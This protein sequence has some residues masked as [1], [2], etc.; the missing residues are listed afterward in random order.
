MQPC[1][2]AP[3]WVGGG[4]GVGVKDVLG[5]VGHLKSRSLE[6]GFCSGAYYD[7]KL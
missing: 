3:G 7:R 2:L 1:T 5:D 6:L 4:G